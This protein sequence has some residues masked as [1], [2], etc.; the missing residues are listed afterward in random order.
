M[1]ARKAA[2]P[3]E[4][5]QIKVTLRH[6][7]PPIWRRIEVGSEIKLD[8]LHRILQEAMGW[9]DSHLHQFI[10]GDSFYGQ[11]DPDFDYDLDMDDETKVK[12]NQIVSGEKFK[13]IY[14]YD[15]GD[16]WEHELLIEKIGPPE[17]GVDYPRCLT[18][19]RACPPEDVGGVWGYETFLEAMADPTH[20]EHEVY[21]EWIGDEFDAEAFDLEGI[22]IG[23]KRI[24]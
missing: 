21:T 10:V 11:P 23:L 12:L 9:T 22:N 17:D 20:P 16:G 6:I 7:R 19:K 24:R 13:F 14:E 8:K 4:I 3:A 2:R 18:G 5:Y 15:F 1:P